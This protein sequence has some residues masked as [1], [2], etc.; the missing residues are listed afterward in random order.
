[1]ADVQVIGPAMVGGIKPGCFRIGNSGGMM[2]NIIASKLY[3]AGS[4]GYVSKSSDM[5]NELNNIL[6]LVTNGTYEGIAI[7]G[8]RYPGSTFIDHLLRYEADSQCKMLVP[9]GEVGGVEEY[10]VIQAVKEGRITK[11]IVAWAA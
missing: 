5:S 10:R 11:P 9:L 3:R 8:D 4:V 2:D 1:E 6:S 7:G